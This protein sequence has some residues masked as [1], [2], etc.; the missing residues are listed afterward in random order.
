MAATSDA[1]VALGGPAAQLVLH[2]VNVLHYASKLRLKADGCPVWSVLPGHALLATHCD[3]NS[4]SIIWP[5]LHR[6]V[7]MRGYRILRAGRSVRD[8][9]IVGYGAPGDTSRVSYYAVVTKPSISNHDNREIRRSCAR[10]YYIAGD[11]SALLVAGTVTWPDADKT[12]LDWSDGEAE[13]TGCA[14]TVLVDGVPYLLGSYSGPVKVLPDPAPRFSSRPSSSSAPSSASTGTLEAS[15]GF[16]RRSECSVRVRE[17]GNGVLRIATAT[18]APVRSLLS[19]AA[20]SPASRR[21]YPVMQL[22]DHLIVCLARV[23]STGKHLTYAIYGIRTGMASAEDAAT[24]DSRQGLSLLH[25]RRLETNKACRK[26]RA[27]GE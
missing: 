13:E 10:L 15:A 11:I 14:F 5:Y 6:T 21:W 8:V 25:Q 9:T 20:V 22:Y 16:L 27:R 24:I 18:L 23:P 3:A 12:W 19:S 7:V 26:K 2:G 17:T 4:L 1:T